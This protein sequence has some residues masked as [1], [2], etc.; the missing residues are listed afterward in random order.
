MVVVVPVPVR[1][2]AVDDVPVADREVSLDVD[3]A[4][5][6]QPGWRKGSA[7]QNSMEPLPTRSDRYT[8]CGSTK[9]CSQL[10]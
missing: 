8:V 4:V 7:K 3:V 2:V 5:V 6:V 10:A 9:P 1:L